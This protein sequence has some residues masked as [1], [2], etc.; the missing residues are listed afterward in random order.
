MYSWANCG[1]SCSASCKGPSKWCIAPLMVIMLI[2]CY[3]EWMCRPVEAICNAELYA[4]M[5]CLKSLVAG[6][7]GWCS[8]GTLVSKSLS[9][10]G[11]RAG[12]ALLNPD[13]LPP[14]QHKVVRFFSCSK[15]S[16]LQCVHLCDM[17]PNECM[18]RPQVPYVTQKGSKELDLRK[19]SETWCRSQLPTLRGV[20]GSCWK[21]WV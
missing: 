3:G 12:K 5:F 16:A 13:I 19:W 6:G 4:R 11:V 2:P 10:W 8:L 21:L 9:G 15:R 17:A 20:E 14:P 1:T 7:K 18:T